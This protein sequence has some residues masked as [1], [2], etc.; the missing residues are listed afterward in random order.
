MP[1]Y[2][3]TN[4]TIRQWQN[5]EVAVGSTQE[6]DFILENNVK[7]SSAKF[8]AGSFLNGVLIPTML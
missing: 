3:Y 4:N 5:R 2:K 8:K 6:F 7:F 1:S